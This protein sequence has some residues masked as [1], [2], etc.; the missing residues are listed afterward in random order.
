MTVRKNSDVPRS[1]SDSAVRSL[2]FLAVV[3]YVSLL[4]ITITEYVFIHP[5]RHRLY[6]PGTLHHRGTSLFITVW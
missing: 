5:R 2:N 4:P 1:R 3:Q 6:I